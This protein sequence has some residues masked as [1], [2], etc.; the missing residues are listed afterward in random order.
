MGN[1]RV[2]FV[3][4]RRRRGR[5]GRCWSWAT[6]GMTEEA[7]KDD[8]SKRVA[9]DEVAKPQKKFY[10]TR[11]HTNVLNANDFWFPVAPS[12]VPWHQYFGPSISTDGGGASG[13]SLPPTDTAVTLSY[14]VDFVDAGCGYGSLL[15]ALARTFPDKVCLGIEIRPKI[16]EYVQK[17]VLA[18][19]TEARREVERMQA[20]VDVAGACGL[21]AYENAWAIHNNA[22]R[23]MPNFFVKEQLSKLFFC[24]PDPHF[25]RKNHRKR[26]ISAP[27]V[28][29]FA[30]CLRKQGVIYIITDVS[31]LME[32]M[33]RY[34]TES[35][36]FER[37]SR[38]SLKSDPV[39]PLLIATDEGLK[40]QRFNGNMFI[41]AF[42]KRDNPS[43]PRAPPPLLG[44]DEAAA[45]AED[46]GYRPTAGG[47][48]R[49]NTW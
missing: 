8:S 19:R 15:I 35:T 4:G 39:V 1:D 12:A 24:F 9:D 49:G 38:S 47:E 33:V 18:L 10:R 43:L 40:V 48:I 16:V 25:K 3:G 21:A 20:D 29:E 36:L 44:N 37:L 41:A 11:A 14:H 28:A 45:A 30:Y 27:L 5:V 26:I 2:A 13:A 17:R 23:F 22:M 31:E 32:W 34:L 42:A 7:G 6:G 46:A